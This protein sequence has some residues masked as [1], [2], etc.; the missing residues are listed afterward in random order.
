VTSCGRLA[1]SGFSLAAV[2]KLGTA[3]VKESP[4]YCKGRERG[5]GNEREKVI[6]AEI[7]WTAVPLDDHRE[8]KGMLVKEKGKE[9]NLN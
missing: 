5:G 6:L 7:V 1:F 4:N 2:D 3:S 9:R 8:L